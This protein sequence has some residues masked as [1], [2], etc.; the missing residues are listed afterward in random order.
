[1]CFLIASIE[2]LNISHLV[3]L[4]DTAVGVD[5]GR[6]TFFSRGPN[7]LFQK[8]GEPKFIGEDQKKKGLRSNLIS[9]FSQ[10]AGE[11][12]K[13]GLKKRILWCFSA[14]HNVSA[15]ASINQPTQK[16]FV[17][18]FKTFGGPLLARGPRVGRSWCRL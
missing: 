15:E 8:F 7:L 17:G 3:L 16:P 1:M 9:V 2:L 4:W 11:D 10:K 5:Q 14:T 18:H 13:K 6:S 12:Q